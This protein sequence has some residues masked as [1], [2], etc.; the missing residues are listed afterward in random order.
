MN[1][2]GH[3][4]QITK[5]ELQNGRQKMIF[6]MMSIEFVQIIKY[7]VSVFTWTETTRHTFEYRLG[8]SDSL[9]FHSTPLSLLAWSDG[10]HD[11][12]PTILLGF[13]MRNTGDTFDLFRKEPVYYVVRDGT[14]IFNSEEINMVAAEPV[15]GLKW[16]LWAEAAIP[17]YR[18]NWLTKSQIAKGRI[19]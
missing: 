16:G 17:R 7:E 18:W 3:S 11:W 8:L 1:T 5:T 10:Q 6:M 4:K 14:F 19:L 12:A 13:P 2:Q 9:N 15:I